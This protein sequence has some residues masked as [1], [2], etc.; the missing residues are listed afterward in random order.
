MKYRNA[1]S[2]LVLVLGLIG[3][4]LGIAYWRFTNLPHPAQ[5]SHH[6][7]MYWVVLRD[8]NDFDHATHIAL[9]NRFAE[10]AKEI[11]TGNSTAASSL[12]KSQNQQLLDNIEILKKTW[13]E[14]RIRQ[15][16]EIRDN[17]DRES[18]MEKQI[19][20]LDDFGDIAFENAKILYPERANEPL[21]TIADE[22]LG[23]ID[24]WLNAT[25]T[26]KKPATLQSVREATVFWLATQDLSIQL[27][28]ARKE[29]AIRVIA[30]LELGMDLQSTTSIISTERSRQLK[31]NALLLM[32]AWGHLLAEEFSA[33]PK[34]KRNE[35]IDK[36]IESVKSWK[37]LEYLQNDV[38]QPKSSLAG[39]TTF[40][41]TIQG[42]VNRAE[43][44]MKPKLK[45]LHTVFQQR[46]FIALFQINE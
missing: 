1:V 5:A 13:F 31:A 39:M 27:M 9:V 23:D 25:P 19:N 4:Y 24:R 11:F 29:I 10:E 28:E 36:K 26:N 18:Y 15:Y 30:E 35:F 41:H 42:W 12:T 44:A 20:L 16:G 32:E 14:D 17:R 46:I 40:N 34:E 8:L 43:E 37:L 22:L 21:T 3:I 33:L 6:Q 2:G 45:R 38:K 7:L